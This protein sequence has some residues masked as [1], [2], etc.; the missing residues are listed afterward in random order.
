MSPDLTPI[1]GL[2]RREFLT[3]V[4]VRI[5][6]R[7]TWVSKYQIFRSKLADLYLDIWYTLIEKVS[8]RLFCDL[9]DIPEED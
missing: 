6:H 5:S 7:R 4:R 1:S 2:T 3:R 9:A 8:L